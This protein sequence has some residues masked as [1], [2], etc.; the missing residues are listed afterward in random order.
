M[1]I[2]IQLAIILFLLVG[3]SYACKCDGTGTVKSSL[4]MSDVVVSGQVLTRE[5]V[6]YSQTL[7]PD[8]VSSIKSR[9]KNN[10][11]KLQ[12]FEMNYIF[13]IEL[14]ITEKYK[15]VIIRDTLTIYTAMNSASCGYKFEVGKSYIV[16]ASKKSYLNSMVLDKLDRNKNLER[17]N[18]YWTNICTRTFEYND[19]EATE[20]K[21]LKKD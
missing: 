19:S 8:S 15:G 18:T 21:A 7:N 3:R 1:R 16:Y 5:L 14:E 10:K 11:Q 12:F 17:E 4:N 13:K 9:L 20:L 2:K 6:S